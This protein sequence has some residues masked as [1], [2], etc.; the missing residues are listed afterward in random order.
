M[1]IAIDPFLVAL[2]L[3]NF[4]LL[5]S[6][7]LGACIRFVAAQGVLLGLLTLTDPEGLSA[8]AIAMAAGSAVLKGVVFPLLLRKALGGAGVR[9]EVQPFVGF[10]ASVLIGMGTLAVSVWLGTRLALPFPLVS[11][12]LVPVAFFT[13]LTGLFL[14]VSRKTAL[15]QVLGYLVLE[16]GVYAFGVPL[17]S[18]APFLVELGVLLDVFVAVF[19]MGIMVY[20]ISREFDHI[21]AAQ[22][23]ELRD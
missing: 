13:M 7:R 15:A 12:L 14:I 4:L 2:L 23:S 9:R 10:T 20:N 16:N 5:G 11:P 8:R 18:K 21:D 19:I 6:S 17:A 3:V 22:L 1:G